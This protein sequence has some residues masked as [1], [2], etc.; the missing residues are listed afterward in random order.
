MFRALV[1]DD[2]FGIRHIVKLALS[3]IDIEVTEAETAAVALARLEDMVPHI[4]LMDLRL[5]DRSGTELARE[6][7][8]RHPR[9]PIVFMSASTELARAA[10]EA[11]TAAYLEKPFKLAQ[12]QSLVRDLLTTKTPAADGLETTP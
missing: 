3:R 1:I 4:I 11:D 5:P 7:R 6:I 9:I 12:L 8:Q 2:E 10:E